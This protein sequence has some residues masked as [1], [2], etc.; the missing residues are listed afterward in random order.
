MI[1]EDSE[2]SP[3]LES[4]MLQMIKDLIGDG[5]VPNC[6]EKWF[7]SRVS[8]ELFFLSKLEIMDEIVAL[9]LDE[10]KMRSTFSQQ[11]IQFLVTIFVMLEDLFAKEVKNMRKNES[12]SQVAVRNSVL[13]VTSI[14]D[15]PVLA[16]GSTLCSLNQ[17][18]SSRKKE[19][20]GQQTI[21]TQY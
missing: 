13:M 21:R 4:K 9:K 15:D 3:K 11:N 18:S 7:L 5:F 10:M 19:N 6:M 20:A 17:P 2:P 16:Q 14:V 12:N 8:M 1:D